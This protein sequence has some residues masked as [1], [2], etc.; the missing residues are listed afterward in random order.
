ML[1]LDL[2]QSPDNK[3][4]GKPVTYWKNG[5]KSVKMKSN[6]VNRTEEIFMIKN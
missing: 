2:I 3:Y 5:K 6:T 1:I 4:K